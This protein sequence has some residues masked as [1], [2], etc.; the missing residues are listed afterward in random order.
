MPYFLP[1]EPAF[2][3]RQLMKR[4]EKSDMVPSVT[5]A[6]EVTLLLPGPQISLC[7]H[8]QCLPPWGGTGPLN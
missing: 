6:G 5:D 7:I 2:F 1:R 4:N 8:W 3:G